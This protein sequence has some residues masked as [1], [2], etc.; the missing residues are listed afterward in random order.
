MKR[1]LWATAFIVTM[2]I[3]LLVVGSCVEAAS[4]AS[5]VASGD[6]GAA[7]DA[8]AQSVDAWTTTLSSDGG[9]GSG[10]FSPFTL[11]STPWVLFS[12][13]SGGVNGSIQANHTFDGGPLGVGQAVLID[14]ANRSIDTGNSVG[15]SL[16]S[17]GT[18][19]VT[20][21]FVGGDP[22]G[23]YRYDD[24]GGAGQSTGE[25]FAYQ[26]MKTLKFAITGPGTYSAGY[27]ASTWNGTF[28]GTID[29]I[30]VFN[31]GAGNGSDVPFNN[32]VVVPEPVSFVLAMLSLA[33]MLI[34]RRARN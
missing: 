7:P 2:A 34:V 29:G 1:H 32:L 3:R 10:F 30:Q 12:F 13:P 17:A 28:A 20:F 15:V 4:I 33:S 18:P 5:Y 21:K 23:V 14:W 19:A 22:D 8:N 27:G 16:T 31:N 26:S 9:R 24:A 25:P 11:S 6:P